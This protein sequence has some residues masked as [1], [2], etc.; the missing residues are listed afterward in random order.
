MPLIFGPKNSRYT[1][2]GTPC[3]HNDL[4]LP[5]NAKTLHEAIQEYEKHFNV[6]IRPCLDPLP[7]QSEVKYFI[8][9]DLESEIIWYVDIHVLRG[10]EEICPKQN[11]A[12]ELETEDLVEMGALIC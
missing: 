8:L 11:L 1:Y 6:A 4:A 5:S 10:N 3:P 7:G 2:T 9:T 12:F